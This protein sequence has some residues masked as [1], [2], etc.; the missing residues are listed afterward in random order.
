MT[1]IGLSERLG[2]KPGTLLSALCRKGSYFGLVPTKLPNG[3]LL[4]PE[5]SVEILTGQAK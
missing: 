4:W 2:L 5:N 1:T 3:R